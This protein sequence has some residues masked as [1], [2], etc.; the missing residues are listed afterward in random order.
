MFWGPQFYSCLSKLIW[1]LK[2]ID[3]NESCF[4][5]LFFYGSLSLYLSMMPFFNLKFTYTNSEFTK[6]LFFPNL[7]VKDNNL[8]YQDGDEC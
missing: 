1:I 2:I 6:Y 4:I 5:F 8:F 3:T 7:N